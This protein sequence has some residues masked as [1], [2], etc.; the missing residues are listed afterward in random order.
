MR[1]IALI[2]DQIDHC[3]QLILKNETVGLR[4]AFI[5]L[6]NAAETLMYR[7]VLDQLGWNEFYEKLMDQVKKLP[8]DLFE[9]YMKENTIPE[10]IETKRKRRTL[11][12]FDEKVAYL[13]QTY[14]MIQKPTAAVLSSLHHYRNEIYHRDVTRDEILRPVAILYFEIVCELLGELKQSTVE[15]DSEDDWKPFFQKYHIPKEGLPMLED[16]DIRII[17]T[18]FRSS[19]AITIEELRD[20]F[21]AYITNR[22]DHTFK[23]LH[24]IKDALNLGS[25]DMVLKMAQFNQL[26][27]IKKYKTRD[28]LLQN[29]EFGN[30]QPPITEESFT[31][32][33][34]K[35]TAFDKTINK[36]DLLTAFKA[37]E[38]EF[39]PIEKMVQTL[40]N[41]IE[42][43]IQYQVDLARGK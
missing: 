42:A 4:M 38:D 21:R 37:V 36:M 29:Q 15:L 12:Y 3:K 26:A 34:Q 14:S 18:G 27:D 33:K 16:E 41:D 2:I 22:L 32:W 19:L 6:D 28:E 1:K 43:A 17:V 8:P 40:N 7:K 10:I 20:T 35:I 31:I 24:F 25:N 23:N 9:R 5:L 30:Y 13:S 39:E 11:Q